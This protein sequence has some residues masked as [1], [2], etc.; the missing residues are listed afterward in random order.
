MCDDG[1]GKSKSQRWRNKRLFES[2]EIAAHESDNESS[3]DDEFQIPHGILLHRQQRRDESSEDPNSD[4]NSTA[5]ASP[6]SSR[7]EGSADSNQQEGSEGDAGSGNPEA[8]SPEQHSS[9]RNSL[10]DEHLQQHEAQENNSNASNNSGRDEG[11]HDGGNSSG[12]SIPDEQHEQANNFNSDDEH[13]SDRSA[14]SDNSGSEQNDV[15]D[16]E[17]SDHEESSADEDPPQPEE[18]PLYPGA[19]ITLGQSLLSILTFSIV[20]QLSGACIA[21]LLGLVTLHCP[22]GNS[23]VQSLHNFR[24]HFSGMEPFVM[25][26]HYFCSSCVYP[27][28]EENGICDVCHKG[29]NSSYFIELPIKNQLAKLLAREGFYEKLQYRFNRRKINNDNIEDIY[30]GALYQEHFLEGGFLSSPDNVSFLGYTDGVR[31]FSTSSTEVWPIYFQIDEL[32]YKDRVQKQNV[33]LAGLW[34]STKPPKPNV[35]LKPFQTALNDF[36]ENGYQL[37][38]HG[39]GERLFKGM[40]LAWTCDLPAKA[41]FMRMIAHNGFYGCSRCET[42]GESFDLGRS[43]VHVYPFSPHV[44]HRQHDDFRV[45]ADQAKQLRRIDPDVNVKGVKGHSLLHSMVPDSVRSVACDIMHGCFLGISKLLVTLWFD[46][47]HSDQP[48]SLN[49]VVDLVDSRLTKI[50]PPSHVQ[51][52][53]KGIKTQLAY[54][55]ALEY[56]MFLVYYSVLVLKDLM[57]PQYY[58]HHCMLVSGLFLLSQ[59]SVSN[60]DK[61]RASELLRTYVERFQDLYGLRWLS[62][63]VHLLLHLHECVEDLGPLWVFSCFPWEDLNGK[64]IKLVHGTRYAGLQIAKAASCVMNLPIYVKKLPDGAV[65]SYCDNLLYSKR[66]VKVAEIISEIEEAVGTY[67]HFHTVPY[68]LRLLLQTSLGLVQGKVSLFQRL[69][70]KGV[71]YYCTSYGRSTKKNSSFLLYEDEQFSGF[72]AVDFFLKWTSC[73]DNCVQG[74]RQCNAQFLFV[75]TRYEREIWAV[76][77]MDDIRLPYCSKVRPTEDSVVLPISCIAGLCHFVQIDN[78]EF[79]LTDINR[80]EV[81]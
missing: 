32:P 29:N 49:H 16:S 79:I 52:M 56:K 69:K 14:I 65:K 75:G 78:E 18:I 50:S 21:D 6:D 45:Y 68:R 19:P 71:M 57:D 7:G 33:I 64:L 63:N 5:G 24:K 43:T 27:L 28:D 36:Q 81:E 26:R 9:P 70:R 41:K 13:V 38:V 22:P 47:A 2:R 44:I 74:C 54:W 58:E 23:C 1:K 25:K 40:L 66:K 11:L 8:G 34:V 12:S 46:S 76:H 35:F 62:L 3:S 61:R 4:S 17:E 72:C 20:H 77:D 59:D 37:P 60:D 15:S 73:N 80:L 42:P 31:V 48:F 30:D 67:K 55:K 39:Q 53:P 51:R 10:D